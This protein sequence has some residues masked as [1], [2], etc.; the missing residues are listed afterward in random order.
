[1]AWGHA[2]KHPPLPFLL[3][4]AHLSH[5]PRYPLS[6][7]ERNTQPFTG[8]LKLMVLDRQASDCQTVCP[9][10]RGAGLHNLGPHRRSSHHPAW[11]VR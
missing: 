10:G 11:P 3:R 4:T 5:Q 9:V 1:M 8:L 6:R 2:R 7:G